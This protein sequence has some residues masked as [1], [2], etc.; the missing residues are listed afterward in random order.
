MHAIPE[1]DNKGL[2]EFALVTSAVVAGLFGLVLPWLFG[3]AWPLWPWV[4]AGVLSLLGLVSPSVVRPIY[5]NWM[6]FGLLLSKITTPVIMGLVFFLVITPMGLIRRLFAKDPM[7]REFNDEVSY[8][9]QS[10]K[11]PP[12]NMEN[13]Y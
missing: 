5:R 8:R 9:V 4:L 10:T 13:P 1:L 6:R 12:E 7:A 2:R 3:F 11:P